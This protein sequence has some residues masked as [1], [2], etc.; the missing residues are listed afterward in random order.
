MLWNVGQNYKKSIIPTFE[1][2]LSDS[3]F[4][5]HNEPCKLLVLEADCSLTPHKVEHLVGPIHS[6]VSD[7]NTLVDSL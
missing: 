4:P 5:I 1:N 6:K 7:M 2:F 3:H